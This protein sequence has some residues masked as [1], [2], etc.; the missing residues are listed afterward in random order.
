[1][2]HSASLPG[3]L[4]DI[5]Q[6]NPPSPYEISKCSCCLLPYW[7]L[8]A[9]GAAL[10]RPWG[11]LQGAGRSHRCPLLPFS[12]VCGLSVPLSI[13][14]SCSSCCL[15]IMPRGRCSA[16]MQAGMPA[17]G[18]KLAAPREAKC[19]RGHAWQSPRGAERRRH[20]KACG[21]TEARSAPA[22]TTASLNA[23]SAV[24][25]SQRTC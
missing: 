19:T 6:Q 25:G 20:L 14:C 17:A 23:A 7:I 13:S 16:G 15:V 24:R 1:M 10:L 12:P 22:R 3:A 4:A 8:W 21:A 11:M 9:G 18:C 5:R 2:G